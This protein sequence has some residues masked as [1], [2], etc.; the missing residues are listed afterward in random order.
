LA[1]HPPQGLLF[2]VSKYA[3]VDRARIELNRSPTDEIMLTV[4]DEG[5]GFDPNQPL[6]SDGGLGLLRLRERLLF[7]NGNVVIDS[8]PARGTRVRLIVPGQA[9]DGSAPP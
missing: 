6:S 1:G 3:G 2:N 9:P 7:L 5:T 4:Q 8:E